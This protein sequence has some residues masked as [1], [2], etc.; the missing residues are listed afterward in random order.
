MKCLSILEVCART[1]QL[2]NVD[3][4]NKVGI[5]HSVENITERGDKFNMNLQ[6]TGHSLIALKP[7]NIIRLL[8]V[9]EGNSLPVTR[10]EDL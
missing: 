8:K 10:L 2:G 9:K 4:W 5:F 7:V 6:K 1:C 3:I